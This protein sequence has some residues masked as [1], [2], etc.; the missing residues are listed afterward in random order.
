MSS[1]TIKTDK[2]NIFKGTRAESIMYDLGTR[3]RVV[4]GSINHVLPALSTMKDLDFIDPSNKDVSVKVVM[5]SLKPSDLLE[6]RK[7]EESFIYDFL[8]SMGARIN[9]PVSRDYTTIVMNMTTNY[10][11]PGK[12][13]CD[14]KDFFVPNLQRFLSRN[15]GPNIF[16]Y[17]G[18]VKANP[19]EE[20]IPRLRPY[21]DMIFNNKGH[22]AFFN[23]QLEE[24]I[25]DLSTK[26][27]AIIGADLADEG[28][29]TIM[30]ALDLDAKPSVN[31]L[32][33]YWLSSADKTERKKVEDILKT[34]FRD[35]IGVEVIYD[36]GYSIPNGITIYLEGGKKDE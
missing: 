12:K 31:I 13:F 7:T 1:Y 26:E 21:V 11:G 24:A 29:Y 4:C 22:N 36:P 27:L 32:Q 20:I 14:E 18:D 3:E 6:E 10:F 19:K 23:S 35:K 16:I 8:Q 30:S 2:Y 15:E 28:F 34:H 33:D 5:N 25:E 17:Q 9:N